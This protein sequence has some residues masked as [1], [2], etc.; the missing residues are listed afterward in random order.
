MPYLFELENRRIGRKIGNKCKGIIQMC[1][2]HLSDA[3]F[4]HVIGFRVF[5]YPGFSITNLGSV[6]AQWLGTCLWC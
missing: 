4:F 2:F 6:V 3:L 1:T 5:V